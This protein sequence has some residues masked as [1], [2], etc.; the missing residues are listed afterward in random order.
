MYGFASTTELVAMPITSIGF[1][2]DGKTLYTAADNVL[3]SWNM[4]KN[5]MLLQTYDT[6]WKGI[7]DM[8]MIQGALMAVGYSLGTINLW[9]C[10][11]NKKIKNTSQVVSESSFVLPKIKPSSKEQKGLAIN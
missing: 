8:A 4:Y 1:S 3:K 7:Q 10:D 5:G 11:V 2:E 9:L 6:N